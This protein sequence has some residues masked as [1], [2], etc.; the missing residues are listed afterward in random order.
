[1]VVLGDRD[2]K[3]YIIGDPDLYTCNLDPA[4]DEY[5]VLAC[6]GL[7]DGI[8]P[9]DVPAIIDEHLEDTDSDFDSLAKSLINVACRK[10]STDNISVIVVRLKKRNKSEY[11]TADQENNVITQ[12]SQEFEGGDVHSTD[13]SSVEEKKSTKSDEG[14]DEVRVSL[15]VDSLIQIDENTTPTEQEIVKCRLQVMCINVSL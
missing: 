13:K 9:E 1:M 5:A 6:D 4:Q 14:R 3:K 7:W 2:Y 12:K 15:V 8:N 10:G 11:N